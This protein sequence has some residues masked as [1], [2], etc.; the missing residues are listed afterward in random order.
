MRGDET[1]MEQVERELAP[2]TKTTT[3]QLK[4]RAVKP[5]IFMKRHSAGA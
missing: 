3:S 2:K 5:Y 1:V 4:N